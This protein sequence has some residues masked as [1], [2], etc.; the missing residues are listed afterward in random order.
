MAI[1]LPIVSVQPTLASVVDDVFQGIVPE[2][3][4]WVSCY[5]SDSPSIHAKIHTR[6]DEVDRNAITLQSDTNLVQISSSGRQPSSR[7]IVTA[8]SLGITPTKVFL[9]AREFADPERSRIQNPSR[10]TA[11]DVTSDGSQFATGYLDG[12]VHLYPNMASFERH[13]QISRAHKSTVTSLHFFPSNRVLLTSGADF[14]LNILSAE[15]QET[16]S[17]NPKVL[18][19]VR[20]F[21][22]HTRG[23]TASA[24][25]ARGK[26][27]LSSSSD[28]TCRLWDVAS[29]S[30]ISM[31]SAGEGQFSSITGMA[32]GDRGQAELGRVRPDGEELPEVVDPREVETS[33]KLVFCSLASGSFEGFDLRSKRSVHAT[34][35]GPPLT[36]IA[37]SPESSLLATGSSNGLVT[38]HDTRALS[39]PLT[40]FTRNTASIEDLTFVPGSSVDAVLFVSPSDALPYVATVRPQGPNVLAEI[41][42]GDCDTVKAIRP[43]NSTEFWTAG[44][45]G[46]V[47]LY[48][49][50]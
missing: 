10:I 46:I 6:L 4:F 9:P 19:P 29:G 3:D 39:S 30:Q 20:T 32:L 36:A 45:D 5:K 48:K 2:E 35:L 33:D 8:P 24:I 12:A 42:G 22:G 13:K 15:L 31:M 50:W 44:D 21:R 38:I 41:I 1:V 17:T 49:M 37:Y 18:E 28:G 25:V 11:F 23:V 26:N 47:R 14:S 40:S 7:Y 43:Q 27:I 16:P 34:S